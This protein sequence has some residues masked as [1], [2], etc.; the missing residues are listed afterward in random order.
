M[1]SFMPQ[2]SEENE[3]TVDL[4]TESMTSA[5]SRFPAMEIKD[6]GYQYFPSAWGRSLMQKYQKIN[7]LLVEFSICF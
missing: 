2:I 1:N 7:K 4:E 5:E 6:H 3:E